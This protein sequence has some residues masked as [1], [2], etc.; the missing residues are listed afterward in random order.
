MDTDLVDVAPSGV[1]QAPGIQAAVSYLLA[2]QT[3][4]GSWKDDARTALRDTDA[5]MKALAAFRADSRV[6]AAFARAQ[7]YLLGAPCSGVD[8]C[9][10]RASALHTLSTSLTPGDL[11]FGAQRSLGAGLGLSWGYAPT[12][13]D[14]ALALASKQ[15]VASPTVSDADWQALKTAQV[16]SGGWSLTPSG[17]A[18]IEATA[19]VLLTYLGLSGATS[20][21]VTAATTAL[22]YLRQLRRSDG[23]FADDVESAAA[24]SWAVQALA[25]HQRLSPQEADGAAQFLSARQGAG[26][27]WAASAYQTSLALKALSVVLV[28]NLSIGATDVV[29]SR[30][31]AF[32]GESVPASVRIHNLGAIASPATTMQVF[33]ANGVALTVP[34]AVA[35][36]APGSTQT[37]AL[38]L[39]TSGAVGTTQA[40]F[41]VDPAGLVGESRKDDN[42]VVAPLS[43]TSSPP[44]AELYV[45]PGTVAPSPGS[46]T[47]LPQS[48]VVSAAVANGGQLGATGVTVAVLAGNARVGASTV[49]FPAGSSQ[50]VSIPVT[51]TGA[52]G[53]VSLTVVIDPDN[54][55]TEST[56]A[57][58][59][60]TGLLPVTL[61]TAVSLA[62][63]SATP[64][65]L[66][67]G[68][69]ATLQFGVRNDGTS[70]VVGAQVGI[71]VFDAQG[72]SQ[73]V[74]PAQRVDVAAGLTALVTTPWRART[75]GLFR[76]VATVTAAGDTT[77]GDNV[78]DTSVTVDASSLPN[79]AVAAS[80]ITTTPSPALEGQPLTVTTRV[81]NVGAA[82]AGTFTATLTDLARGGLELKRATLGPLAPGAVATLSTTF[83]PS[84]AELQLLW[85]VDTDSQVTEFAED[86][87]SAIVHVQ[88]LSLP[89]LTVAA[90]DIQV[91]PSTPRV[92][93][94][95]QVAVSVTNRG[96]QPAQAFTVDLYAESA[97]GTLLGT[98][99]LATLAPSSSSTA[100]FAWT[101]RATVGQQKLVA[102]VNA[103]HAS[104]E[105][106][107]AN[108]QAETSVAV[109]DAT[110]ALSEP[111]F[112]P[113]G[114]G[115]KDTT[116]VQ[117]HAGTAG[118]ALVTVT[119]RT[120]SIVRQLK[121]TLTA[122]DGLVTWDG[123]G[124]DGALVPDGPYTVTV[125][126]GGST[127]GTS[128]VVVDTNASLLTDAVGTPYL[129]T[130][131]LE[132]GLTIPLSLPS[133]TEPAA[134]TGT[135]WP[136]HQR[137][138]VPMNRAQSVLF[139]GFSSDPAAAGDLF[140]PERSPCALYVEDVVG[141]AP[142]RISNAAWSCDSAFYTRTYALP[143][144]P[145]SSFIVRSVNAPVGLAVSPNDDRVAIARN[146]TAL[147]PT[148]PAT[149]PASYLMLQGVGYFGA[150]EWMSMANGAT[151][152][153]ATTPEID[154]RHPVVAFA[155]SG[156]SFF[157]QAANNTTLGEYASP[158]V[159]R[160]FP[161]FVH[162]S[163]RDLMDALYRADGTFAWVDPT[164]IFA[165][166][167]P[168]DPATQRLE[169][170]HV[171]DFGVSGL[172]TSGCTYFGV[173]T[174]ACGHPAALG[175]S[176]LVASGPVA[177]NGSLFHRA[178][179]HRLVELRGA[180]PALAYA[181][182]E[183][184]VTRPAGYDCSS[185][186]G[187]GQ[188][189]SPPAS[190]PPARA[191][192][193]CPT[194]GRRP[195]CSLPQ[196]RSDCSSRRSHR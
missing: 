158:G 77:P 60:A 98:A 26:G 97:G 92:S 100:H 159:A 17:P 168:G 195:G 16:A 9:A 151:T 20:A 134:Y 75:P 63:A 95:A 166:A 39:T 176:P 42:R 24:T 126:A 28:P 150:V 112:S 123:R 10:R 76:F 50:V 25:A 18:R 22:Q 142:V 132:R 84:A 141:G 135:S 182:V 83:T 170:G 179:G 62:S 5:A 86:D 52:S 102:V 121:A 173:P 153:V 189:R 127:V 196:T 29:L 162:G 125:V 124:D 156:V 108:D 15:L 6:A 11:S 35:A 105:S 192:S 46:L 30:A 87:N 111:Y 186:F 193:S 51:L 2:Q 64:T 175:G 8:T 143:S 129:L 14:T 157:A 110:V 184:V 147:S 78:A 144:Y 13:V 49:D 119:D 31:A 188:G 91:M 37:V 163:P 66:M 154:E 117:F 165:S 12:P 58:N 146:N 54:A 172:A 180:S 149:V 79:L 187:F 44:T 69:D 130:T 19:T 65:E 122:L 36:I 133:S 183:Q 128:S 34:V 148:P 45:T 57:N 7:T 113:N 190:R 131:H 104:A 152:T 81:T 93:N 109:Q 73:G 177:N 171:V 140:G 74:L 161:S 33:G 114:D 80:D 115:V 118:P 41:V 138:L 160:T 55:V 136:D 101:T 103:S 164:G 94:S 181:G 178:L 43:I 4:D 89:D 48:F 56:K 3:S 1:A 71:E 61:T 96:G 191:S 145:T 106:N 47:R 32:D 167:R 169:A 88:P 68:R 67:Q 174:Y 82:G 107:Y 70:A 120:G 27:D 137:L 53:D 139:V 72:V 23:S 185:D 116:D 59:Q 90:A 155:P 40:F 194:R 21:D 85:K 99:T 38:T